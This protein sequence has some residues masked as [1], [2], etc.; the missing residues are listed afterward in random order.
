MEL[1]TNLLYYTLPFILVLTI[2]VFIHEFGHFWVARRVGV[3]VEIFSIGF[4]KELFGFNDKHGTRWK[5]CAI[6]LG[7]Y[8]KMFGDKSAASNSNEELIKQLSEEEKKI[9]FPCKS[10]LSKSA[11]VVAGPLA[12]Y[13]L[14]I[15]IFTGF[16]IVYGVP[17]ASAKITKILPGSAASIAGIEP[18]DEIID[19]NGAEINNFNDIKNIMSINVG[20]KIN[21]SFKKNDKIIAKEITPQEFKIK[22]ILGNE[23]KTY[24]LGIIAENIILEKKSLFPAIKSAVKECYD[25]SLMS[26]KAIGQI[27]TGQRSSKELGGPIKIA[28]YS[29]K[30]AESG[31]QSLLW[32]IALLSVNLGLMNLLPIPALDGGHLLVYLTEAVLGKKIAAKVQNFGF[33][34]GVIILIM[35]TI[36]VTF[37]DISSLN[38]FKDK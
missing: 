8:V 9:A 5:F 4:G 24:R 12:N 1:I 22:D 18:G 31:I 2:V 11:I 16:F 19:I 7:G 23:A 21:I 32:F 10:L 13:L 29:A 28:Q 17:N 26:L 25:L 15:I 38:I 33:Q 6:P 20:E 27:I 3:K 35:L 34:I 37:N 30:S 14:A 36:F